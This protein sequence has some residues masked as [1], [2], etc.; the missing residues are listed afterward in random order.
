LRYTSN[1]VTVITD[2]SYLGGAL[3]TIFEGIPGVDHIECIDSR[4]WTTEPN[5]RIDIR[6]SG[7][8][9]EPLP[10]SVRTADLALDCNTAFIEFERRHGG[11]PP[12]GI[13]RFWLQH[14]GLYTQNVNPLPCYT[15]NPKKQTEADAW[16]VSKNPQKKPLVGIVL[17]AGSQARDWD[18]DGK[19]TEV[20]A[21]LHNSGYLPVGIDPVRPL[22]NPYGISCIGKPI[23]FV[24]AVVNR[25]S[26]IL[27]PDTGILHL[28]QAVDTPQV[29]LW[30]IMPPELRVKGYNCSVVPK[31]TLGYCQTAE[32]LNACQCRWRFQQWSC[33]RRIT[34]NMII[35]GL[36]EALEHWSHDCPKC[37]K[38]AAEIV[39]EM[40]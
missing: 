26:I 2:V 25:C 16:L 21:W 23:D 19:S 15:I 40:I 4:E 27:T 39:D 5:R 29:A 13:A 9:T 11:L 33:L 24:A 7:A 31:R 18:F 28:A 37:V 1:H 17:R 32:E 36:E 20:A 3:P 35:E 34:L 12:Y 8:T 30:G 14:H 10:D 38:D 22:S 6:L